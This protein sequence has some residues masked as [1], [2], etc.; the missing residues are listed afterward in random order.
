MRCASTCVRASNWVSLFPSQGQQK[1][2]MKSLPESRCH[3]HNQTAHPQSFTLSPHPLSRWDVT[4]SQRANWQSTLKSGRGNWAINH[5]AR[6]RYMR[7]HK[8]RPTRSSRVSV[9][10]CREKINASF[11]CHL[12]MSL[13]HFVEMPL[14]SL[15]WLVNVCGWAVQTQAQGELLRRRCRGHHSGLRLM[16]TQVGRGLW[17]TLKEVWLET[18]PEKGREGERTIDGD[19]GHRVVL[20]LVLQEPPT[21]SFWTNEELNQVV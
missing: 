21:E 17:H 9:A 15:L 2:A 18:L 1:K 14:Q 13:L 16:F 3:N 20:S 8:P 6:V 19:P 10:Y 4:K 7:A 11:N 12:P 5:S